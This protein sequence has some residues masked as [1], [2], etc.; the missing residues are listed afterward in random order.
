MLN[1]TI[2]RALPTTLTLLGTAVVLIPFAIMDGPGMEVTR[3]LAIVA[4]G[5]LA[6]TAVVVLYL[7]P[8]LYL[9][10]VSP[11]RSAAISPEPPPLPPSTAPAPPQPAERPASE[12]SPEEP[13]DELSEDAEHAEPA[14]ADI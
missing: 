9:R 3:P 7:L 10:L 1:G 14:E 12:A 11:P 4:L 13:S 5:G 6:S 8:A 2:D